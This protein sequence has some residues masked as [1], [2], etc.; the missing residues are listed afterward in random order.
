MQ[1][2]CRLPFRES[3]W[4]SLAIYNLK[5][6]TWVHLPC[7]FLVDSVQHLRLNTKWPPSVEGVFIV[8]SLW[9]FTAAAAAG[10][11]CGGE[12]PWA[13]TG[14]TGLGVVV[15]DSRMIG[16]LAGSLP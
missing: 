9:E 6:Y 7:S 16:G 15:L 4:P 1:G 10:A 12:G 3:L 14:W 2:V 5:H 13:T 8:G 11:V